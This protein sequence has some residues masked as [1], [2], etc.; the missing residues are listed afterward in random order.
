MVWANAVKIICSG[1]AVNTYSVFP[2]NVF[3][4]IQ[5]RESVALKIAHKSVVS[6]P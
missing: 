6:F 3:N 2:K 4:K 1:H 5:N